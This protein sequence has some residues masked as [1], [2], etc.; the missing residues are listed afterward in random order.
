MTCDLRS[1]PGQYTDAGK[2]EADSLKHTPLPRHHL[3]ST[4]ALPRHQI[5]QFD[6]S[7]PRGPWDQ[8]FS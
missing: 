4:E 2:P 1:V 6:S 7:E 5:P 3:E 8:R